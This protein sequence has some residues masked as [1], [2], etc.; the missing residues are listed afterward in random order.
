[1]LLTQN[2]LVDIL[3]SGK[4]QLSELKK[5]LVPAVVNGLRELKEK[6]EKRRGE[7]TK[8]ERRDYV[9][10]PIVVKEEFKEEPAKRL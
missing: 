3:N 8:K 2:S 7:N 10:P 4:K 6:K 1:M 9:P 5:S